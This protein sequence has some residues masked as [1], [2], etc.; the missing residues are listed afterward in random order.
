MVNL[1]DQVR[2]ASWATPTARDFKDGNY[3]PNVPENALLGRQVWQA[4]GRTLNGFR[5]AMASGGQLNPAHS[6]WLQGYPPA[7]D[8]CAVTAMRSNPKSRRRSSKPIER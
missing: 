7:W 3:Q 8:D 5:A 1:Q 2:L 6:R 4:S